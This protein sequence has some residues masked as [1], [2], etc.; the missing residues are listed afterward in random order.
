[1]KRKLLKKKGMVPI[2][3]YEG[4]DFGADQWEME[5]ENESEK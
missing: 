2:G 4:R 5:S 3:P 1:M